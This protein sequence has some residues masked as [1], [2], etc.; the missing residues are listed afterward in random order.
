LENRVT[1]IVENYRHMSAVSGMYGL[2]DAFKKKLGNKV[3]FIEVDRVKVTKPTRTNRLLAF[4]KLKEPILGHEKISP[5]TLLV[6]N[7]AARNA[8]KQLYSHEKNILILSDLE[9]QFTVSL[10][11]LPPSQKN[12]IV[13][14]SHQHPAWY[15]LQGFDLNSLAGIKRLFVFSEDQKCFFRDQ[16]N[17]PISKIHHGVNL[18]FFKPLSH[19][20]ENQS[21]L[22]VGSWQRDFQLLMELILKVRRTHPHIVFHLVVPLKSRTA[23]L[24]KVAKDSKVFFHQGLTAEALRSLYHAAACVVLPLISATANN[25]LLEAMATETPIIVSE[26]SETRYY[27]EN[28]WNGVIPVASNLESFFFALENLLNKSTP[29][30][31]LN[32][33]KLR[34]LDWNQIV[35]HIIEDLNE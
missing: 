1:F 33:S 18:D 22:F 25:T 28:L 19:K 8:I 16:L 27:A 4:L 3:Y 5:H 17:I 23:E 31:A 34:C 15:K 26:S 20:S 11:N 2:F 10:S 30:S 9:N 12:R 6:H 7:Y 29:I 14:I 21:I 24:Y 13:G 32:R 35:Q